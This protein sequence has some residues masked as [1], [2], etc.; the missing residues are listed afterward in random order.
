MC[1]KVV[2]RNLLASY[3]ARANL[4]LFP[5]KYD[6]SS[7]V[8]IEAASQHLPVLFLKGTAT[9]ATVTD[10]VNGFIEEDDVN[11]YAKRILEIMKNKKLYQEVCNNAYKD[12]YKNWDD[13][14][15]DVYERY[16]KLINDKRVD[17]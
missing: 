5:S 4:F 11:K 8:Q 12:L 16:L 1:G 2:D 7:I 17:K 3:Y 14:I 6:S 13:T 10:N 9:S 15:K